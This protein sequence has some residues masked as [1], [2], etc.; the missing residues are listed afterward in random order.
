MERA[1]S[2]LLHNRTAIIIAHRLSTL[3]RTN[4]IMILDNGRITEHGSRAELAA[5]EQSQYY[6]ILQTGQTEILA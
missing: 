3:H 2:H 5:D 1:V 4:E 6:R